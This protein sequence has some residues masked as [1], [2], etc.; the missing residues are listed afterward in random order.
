MLDQT[1]ATIPRPATLVVV[2]DDIVIC[3]IWVRTEVTLDEIAGLLRSEAEEN[4][5]PVDVSGIQPNGV[6]CLGSGVAI[7]QEV[8]G[9]LR[10]TCHLACTL[11][12]EDED[13]E[14][15]STLR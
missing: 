13:V 5:D 4:V 11:Q 14:D 10:W 15:K 3:R 12:P 9:H 1:H 7:L 8:V 6:P 2:A